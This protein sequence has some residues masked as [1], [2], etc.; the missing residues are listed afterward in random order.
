MLFPLEGCVI[1][2]GIDFVASGTQKRIIDV[3]M[4]G[5]QSISRSRLR[6]VPTN[7]NVV[8]WI[9]SP[10]VLLCFGETVF[11]TSVLVLFWQK[12]LDS[13]TEICKNRR[14]NG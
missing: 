14:K 10:Q 13:G 4:L 12:G 3:N 6:R 5:K 2:H 7:Q 8:Q 9:V 1:F 11:M